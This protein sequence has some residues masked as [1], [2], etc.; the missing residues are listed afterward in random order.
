LRRYCVLFFIEIAGRRLH[1]AGCTANPTARWVAPQ[2]RNLV[3][4]LDGR[5]LRLV[6][7]DSDSKFTAAFDW[8]FASAGLLHEY[9]ITA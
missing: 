3:H 2:A 5:S 4:D 7:H 8:A 6:V 1:I 9:S